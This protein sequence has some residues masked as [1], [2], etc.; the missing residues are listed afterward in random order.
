M[1]ERYLKEVE[2][3]AEGQLSEDDGETFSKVVTKFDDQ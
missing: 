2:M 3:N 1:A